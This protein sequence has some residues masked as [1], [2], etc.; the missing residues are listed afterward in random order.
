MEVEDDQIREITQPEIV[1]V[2]W[3]DA[4]LVA[5]AKAEIGASGSGQEA[6]P[7]PASVPGPTPAPALEDGAA[8]DPRASVPPAPEPPPDPPPAVVATSEWNPVP[9]GEDTPAPFTHPHR[10]SANE[11]D[12]PGEDTVV[13]DP[14]MQDRLMALRAAQDE[15]LRTRYGGE[16]VVMFSDLVGSTGYYERHGDLMGRQKMLTH[17]ALLFPIIRGHN[18]TIIKTI[19][20]SIMACFGSPAQAIDAAVE[21]QQALQAYNRGCD[22]PDE[23]I[24]IRLGLNAGSAIAEDGDLHGDA[25]NVAARL[26]SAAASGDILLSESMVEAARAQDRELEALGELAF[27]GKSQPLPV[28]RLHWTES[29]DEAVTESRIIATRYRLHQEIGRGP[30]GVVYAAQDLRLRVPV[31]VKLLHRFILEDQEAADRFELRVQTMASLWHEGIV[32]VL[33]SSPRHA[34]EP[35]Y[36]ADRVD[37]P[38]LAL[39]LT[40]NGVPEPRR[41][42]RIVREL[43]DAVAFAHRRGVVHANIKPENVLVGPGNQPLLADFGVGRIAQVAQ[44]GTLIASPAYLAPEQVVG[45]RADARTDVYGL[46][47]ILYFLLTA[48]PPH[49]ATASFDAMRAVA[50]GMHVPLRKLRP[51]LP[52]EVLNL[53][54]RGLASAPNQRHPTVVALGEAIDAVLEQ[55]H[56]RAAA[57][58]RAETAPHHVDDPPAAIE[59]TPIVRVSVPDAIEPTPVVRIHIPAEES[60]AATESTWV[61]PRAAPSDLHQDIATDSLE[62]NWS[63]DPRTL[64]RALLA[65][66]AVAL[67]ASV[68]LIINLFGGS[69]PESRVLDSPAAAGPRAIAAEGTLVVEAAAGTEVFV[70]GQS[71]GVL[72]QV[73]T[74]WLTAGQHQLRLERPGHLPYQER[75]T[76]GP[77]EKLRRAVALPP[78]R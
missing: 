43:C 37:G 4:A 54:D 36:V 22:D 35:F 59:P 40:R 30:V 53:C 3:P 70:N 67:A 31:A 64:Q 10:Q 12:E 55:G 11:A 42:L 18:G 9:H 19:G 28:H 46:V 73:K 71:L 63:R 62:T 58:V 5:E 74:I 6:A 21:M 65:M 32:R 25:V 13:L 27:K 2:G 38:D 26:Q 48:R 78:S 16:V 34:E 45:G 76:I 24:H 14:E 68:A 49:K 17:N 50:S 57:G 75:L 39:W 33:D 20:D 72:P 23:E 15:A 60:S 41:A 7:A 47:A 77:G 66:T 69:Q 8:T 51:D 1:P 61:G 56:P 29:L 44:P 52:P